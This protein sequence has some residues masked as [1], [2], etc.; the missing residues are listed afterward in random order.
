M[1]TIYVDSE[2]KCHVQND[3]T[4]TPVETAYFDGKC[5]A[6]V[7]GHCYEVDDIGTAVYTWKDYAELDEVQREYERQLL[8]DYQTENTEL[9]A[10]QN[11]L[12]TSY[13]E[14]VNSI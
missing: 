1:R 2:H 6:F 8:L 4:M 9:K 5:D 11:E 10:Q 7:N 3:G 12:I 14:G 13:N